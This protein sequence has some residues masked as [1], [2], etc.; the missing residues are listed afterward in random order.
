M[1]I[2][3]E[4]PLFLRGGQPFTKG[5]DSWSRSIHLP[6]PSVIWGAI[7]SKLLVDNSKL[8][9][10]MLKAPEDYLQIKGIYFYNEDTD[11]YYVHAPLDIFIA[12]SGEYINEKYHKNNV[13]S[14]LAPDECQCI[15][16]PDTEQT[17]ERV[18]SFIISLASLNELYSRREY[19]RMD[20]YSLDHVL[21][22]DSKIGIVRSESGVTEQTSFY[23]IDLTQFKEE[24]CLAVNILINDDL[25]LKKSGFLKIGGKGKVTSYYI[26]NR[27]RIDNNLSI[28]SELGKILF[29][30]PAYFDNGWKPSN[31]DIISAVVGRPL[32]VGGF[33]IKARQPKVMHKLV[34]PG[35]VYIIKRDSFDELKKSIMSD[36]YYYK[37]GFNKFITI[38]IGG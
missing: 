11:L 8:K 1:K 33:D 18:D 21:L 19:K 34:P 15:V 31:I 7:F 16:L 32:L 4:E 38:N 9:E 26:D 17:C 23:R 12:E 30:T 25:Y 27:C 13:I 6:M 2:K 20:L 5:E 36:Q 24:W 10:D 14:S 22:R 28:T 37:R 29:I 3:L 35:S